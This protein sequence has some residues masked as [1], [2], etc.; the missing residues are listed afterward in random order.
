MVC[1]TADMVVMI[2]PGQLTEQDYTYVSVFSRGLYQCVFHGA[3]GVVAC[4]IVKT[5]SD[6]FTIIIVGTFS[7]VSTNMKVSQ[8]HFEDQKSHLSYI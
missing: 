5:S 2:T 7:T 4:R 1:F 3:G 6:K 8:C